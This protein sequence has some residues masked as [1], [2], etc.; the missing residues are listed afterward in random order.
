M[1]SLR[2]R[3][4]TRE[5][6]SRGGAVN[7]AVATVEDDDRG[8]FPG[9]PLDFLFFFPSSPFLFLINVFFYFFSGIDL[10]GHAK[11]LQKL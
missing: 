4:M 1:L 10:N 3:G 8:E 2:Q 9:N 6:A 5:A 11:E 7:G